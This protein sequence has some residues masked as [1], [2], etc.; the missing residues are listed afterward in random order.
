MPVR[1]FRELSFWAMTMTMGL[2]GYGYAAESVN[3]PGTSSSLPPRP[4][5]P[6]AVRIAPISTKI[7]PTIQVEFADKSADL[8]AIA[9]KKIQDLMS[10]LRDAKIEVIVVVGHADPVEGGNAETLMNISAERANKARS[11]IVS[12]GADASRVYSTG[13]GDARSGE[14]KPETGNRRVVVEA[15]GIVQR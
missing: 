2:S 11:L 9:K 4:A 3:P 13:V 8:D 15:V 14:A 10:Q 5:P 7:T 12:M 1:W 6:P